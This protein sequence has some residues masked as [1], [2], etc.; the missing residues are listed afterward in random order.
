MLPAMGGLLSRL[1]ASSAALVPFFGRRERHPLVAVVRLH[2]AIGSVGVGRGGLSITSTARDLEAAFTLRGVKAVALA[3]NS[4]GGSPVQ[5]NLIYRRIRSLSEEHK[6]PVIAFCEDAAASGGYW[7]ACAGD[8][9]YADPNSIVGSIGVVSGGFGFPALLA[10]LGVERR[11]YV[12]GENKGMLDAFSPERASD[13]E[14]LHGIQKVVHESFKTLV[15]ERRGERLK[16]DEPALFTGA[17][18]TGAQAL[19]FGLVDGLGDLRTVLRARFGDKVRLKVVSRAPNR[20]RVLLGRGTET[21][22]SSVTD[23]PEALVRAL[24]A[25]WLWARLGL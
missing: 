19:A 15:R 24:E 25:R 13:V 17:F 2:G 4:P 18:W 3:I 22:T 16:T 12:Q 1:G 7:L 10:K 9:I 14:H 11:L 6:V 8:E 20:L 23:L 5:S 21:P